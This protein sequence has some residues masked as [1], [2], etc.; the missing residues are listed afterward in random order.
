MKN[1]QEADREREREREKRKMVLCDKLV[2][3]IGDSRG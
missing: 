1:A 2:V 3:A